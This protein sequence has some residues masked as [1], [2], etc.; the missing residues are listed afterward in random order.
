M[1]AWS[2]ESNTI[3]FGGKRTP[4]QR[5]TEQF[6]EGVVFRDDH[7]GRCKL[8]WQFLVRMM[9]D[10]KWVDEFVRMVQRVMLRLDELRDNEKISR[11]QMKRFEEFCY[12]TLGRASTIWRKRTRSANLL[13]DEDP[14]FREHGE[15]YL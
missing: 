1:K 11:L 3:K 14:A 10:M 7:G 5:Q 15:G 2:Q 13:E 12:V 8:R 4:S 9:A 6:A